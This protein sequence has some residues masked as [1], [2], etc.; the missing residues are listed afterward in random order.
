MYESSSTYILDDLNSIA[1]CSPFS[2]Q[3][4]SA[5]TTF[6]KSSPRMQ[7]PDRPNAN[8]RSPSVER[9]TVSALPRD[10]FVQKD[11]RA[12]IVSIL[13]PY[14]MLGALFH[15]RCRRPRVSARRA[16]ASRITVSASRRERPAAFDASAKTALTIFDRVMM[17][18]LSI[19]SL[20]AWPIISLIDYFLK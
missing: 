9:G 3:T 19:N 2:M 6:S 20:I 8:A 12:S 11:A 15:L 13:I 16:S 17:S 1:L 5:S 4:S 10:K 18:Y 14:G 7:Y